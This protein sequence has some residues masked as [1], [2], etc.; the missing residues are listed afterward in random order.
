MGG[1]CHVVENAVYFIRHHLLR[2]LH[3]NY[4]SLRDKQI[5]ALPELVLSEEMVNYD[6]ASFR[7]KVNYLL[8]LAHHI[9][10]G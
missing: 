4:A 7:I 1:W 3:A 2:F 5:Q 9:T 10:L 6:V 8:L